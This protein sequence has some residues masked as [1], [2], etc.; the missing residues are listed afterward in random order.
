MQKLS[1][2]PTN[3]I[4]L[5]LLFNE[6]GMRKLVSKNKICK[7]IW[8]PILFFLEI[9]FTFRTTIAHK[10]VHNKTNPAHNLCGKLVNN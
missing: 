7:N 5:I 2:K 8:R 4:P 3:Q 9:Y 6:D 1:N 10:I